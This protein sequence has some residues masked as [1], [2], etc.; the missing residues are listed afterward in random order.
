MKINYITSHGTAEWVETSKSDDGILSIQVTPKC[1]GVI[2]IGSTA[3]EVKNGRVSIPL[4]ALQ[5]G[6]HRPKLEVDT[7]VFIAEGFYK[8]GYDI[9]M[10]PTEQETIRRLVSRYHSLEKICV[11]LEKKVAHLETLCQG[12]R[13]FDFERTENEKQA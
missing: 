5:N 12:H 11:T 9:S 4:C 10:L 1:N 13:I 7:G 3:F 8:N 2:T 6:E